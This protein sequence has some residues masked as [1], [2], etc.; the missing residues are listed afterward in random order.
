MR[1]RRRF[2]S[3][4]LMGALL[5]G[6]LTLACGHCWAMA[7]ELAAADD[8]CHQSQST[9]ESP[10]CCEHDTGP[11]CPEAEIGAAPVS[12]A[13]PALVSA[14]P[15]LAPLP[16]ATL[17]RAPPGRVPSPILTATGPPPDSP[18]LYLRHCAF[19]K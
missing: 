13:L 14:E 19:L 16:V 18:P 8:H 12:Q 6:W 11:V 7:G 17:P 4:S 9:P 3:L 1:T 2:T 5:A 10:D 15:E